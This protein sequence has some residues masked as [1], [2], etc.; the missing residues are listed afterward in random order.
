MLADLLHIDLCELGLTELMLV[1]P[2]LFA[3]VVMREQ[4]QFLPSSMKLW[5]DDLQE[6]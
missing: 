5:L 4:S 1:L 6:R 3:T 2:A